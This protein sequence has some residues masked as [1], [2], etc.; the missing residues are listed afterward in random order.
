MAYKDKLLPKYG[1]LTTIR[2]YTERI[3]KKSH[4]FVDCICDCGKELRLNYK[5]LKSGNTKSCGCYRKDLMS[6]TKKTHGLTDS[7]EY[8]SYRA[9][10][11]RCYS[12]TNQDYALYGGRGISVCDRWLDVDGFFNFIEDMGERPK[13]HSL[14]RKDSNGNYT[15][16]N[17]KW[18]TQKEQCRNI[19][20]NR[21]INYK[22]KDFIMSELCEEYNI[23]YVMFRRRLERGWEIEDAIKA[24]KGIKYAVYL[25]R[26]FNLELPKEWI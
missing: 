11:S 12:E 14:D 26:E 21:I 22:N 6:K 3:G 8:I 1:R 20:T 24:P 9:M 19:S 2:E 7:K 16:E 18:S 4:H 25:K 17:C 13:N 15:P 10:K 23:D 5:S